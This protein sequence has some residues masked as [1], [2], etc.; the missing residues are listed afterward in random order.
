MSSILEQDSLGDDFDAPGQNDYD[1]GN[2]GELA[3]LLREGMIGET[4]ERL[5]GEVVEIFVAPLATHET[6]RE[7]QQ[8]TVTQHKASSRFVVRFKQ[9]EGTGAGAGANVDAPVDEGEFVL[10]KKHFGCKVRQTDQSLRGWRVPGMGA[11]EAD[12]EADHGHDMVGQFFIDD[13]KL[14]VV[15]G[16]GTGQLDDEGDD[17][18][19]V[20]YYRRAGKL[21]HAMV[22]ST[23]PEVRAWV[24]KTPDAQATKAKAQEDKAQAAVQEDEGSEHDGKESEP[25]EQAE[26]EEEAEEVAA[27]AAA[28]AEAAAEA[29]SA[30]SAARAAGGGGGPQR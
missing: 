28:A 16:T 6:N 19:M 13:K 12:V 22:Q 24:N 27:A 23:V 20:A 4:P 11:R 15:M 2:Y 5:V 25:E 29:R 9:H 14:W 10:D 21:D 30:R 7:W 8:G 17:W 3:V 26:S 1:D 18:G